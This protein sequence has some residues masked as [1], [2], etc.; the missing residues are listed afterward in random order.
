[1]P[2]PVFRTSAGYTPKG[3]RRSVEPDEVDT[4]RT[5]D[6]SDDEDE[7]DTLVPNVPDNKFEGDEPNEPNDPI[8]FPVYEVRAA[9]EKPSSGCAKG[10]LMI[11]GMIAIISLG[12]IAIGI[13]FLYFYT[14]AETNTF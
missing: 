8:E 10:A 1:M 9:P 5:E 2:E 14:P 7:I 11:A 6:A 3:P 4:L 13:Y 12:L